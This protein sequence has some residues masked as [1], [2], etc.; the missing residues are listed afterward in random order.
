M[1]GLGGAMHT[2]FDRQA[3][4]PPAPV[5]A[6]L[7]RRTRAGDS[8]AFAELYARHAKLATHRA[9]WMTRST[10]ESEDLVA[11]AFTRI[12]AAI[13]R[14]HGPVDSF[15][16]YL[17]TTLRYLWL[18]KV[19]RITDVT[20]DPRD[21]QERADVAEVDEFTAAVEASMVASQAFLL[22]P[23]RWQ[24]ILWWTAV[25]GRTPKEA[26]LDVGS[27]PAAMAS[28]SYRARQAFS[29]AY[30]ETHLGGSPPPEPCSEAARHLPAYVRRRIAPTHQARVE[31]HLA[32][33]ERCRST[34][35]ELASINRDLRA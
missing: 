9:R 5:D 14:G 4:P 33:C 6:E 25:D 30:L 21:I 10:T 15:L 8:A 7:I 16:P 34:E 23:E 27:S 17:L 11:E 1:A 3:T 18:A 2:A 19:R 28:L 29:E 22:L 13:R 12:L 24:S 26:T 31:A 32:S 35:H 20:V